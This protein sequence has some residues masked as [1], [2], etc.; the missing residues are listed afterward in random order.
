M[1]VLV[2]VPMP[3]PGNPE[4]EESKRTRPKAQGLINSSLVCRM[5][6]IAIE[7]QGFAGIEVMNTKCAAVPGT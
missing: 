6:V 7:S 1:G 5:K 3:V 4:N 2:P